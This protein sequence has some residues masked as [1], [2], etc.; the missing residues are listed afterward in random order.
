MDTDL[1]ARVDAHPLWYHTL[2]LPG[3]VVTPGW[4]DLRGVVAKMPWPDVAG[5]RC[6]DI[7]TWDGFLAFEMERRGAAEVVATD[8]RDHADWDHLPRFRAEAIAFYEENAG[9]KGEGFVIA[10]EALGSKV[11]REWINIYDLSPERV[12]T[13]DVV[14]L[15]SLLLHLQNPFTALDAVRSV[16]KE[17]GRFLSAEQINV[18]T[19]LFARRRPLLTLEG[20]DGRWTVPNAAGHRKMLEMAGF[21][22]ISETAPYMIPFGPNQPDRP[23]GLRYQRR[24]LAE[25]AVM[26]SGEE[27]VPHHAVLSQR[28]I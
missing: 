27:G 11:E 21:D 25:R 24:R 5:K 9:T 2:E 13:F 15:G 17:G 12:G 20:V 4:F 1:R 23:A 26:R 6:L 7:G 19:S 14:V 28:A 22:T 3:G 10:K 16:V 18:P 8:I